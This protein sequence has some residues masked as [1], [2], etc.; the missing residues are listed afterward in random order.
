MNQDSV[1][2]RLQHSRHWLMLVLTALLFGLVAILVD[3]KPQVDENFFFSSRD[4]QFQ[5]SG[6]IDRIFPSGSQLIVSVAAPNMVVLQR[7]ERRDSGPA[8][9]GDRVP[10]GEE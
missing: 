8:K 2:N 1:L 4:P 6:K 9:L 3:L 10:T 7:F 5:E